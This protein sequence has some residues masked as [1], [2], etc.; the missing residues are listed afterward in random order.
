[1]MTLITE[2][3]LDRALCERITEATLKSACRDSD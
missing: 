2:H 1:M 3:D